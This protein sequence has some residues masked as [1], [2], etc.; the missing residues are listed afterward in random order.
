MKS[1]HSKFIRTLG[2]IALLFLFNSCSRVYIQEQLSETAFDAKLLSESSFH[3]VG[4]SNVH[5]NDYQQTYN[6][7][8]SSDEAFADALSTR[9]SN[10]LHERSPSTQVTQLHE[11]NMV[12]FQLNSLSDS[13]ISKARGFFKTIPEQYVI[14]LTNVQIGEMT[15]LSTTTSN[16]N[17]SFSPNGMGSQTTTTSTS[18]CI[19]NMTV[20]IWDPK[21]QRKIVEFQAEGR[22]REFL[23]FYSWALNSAIADAI[24]H[25]IAFLQTG[26]TE[27]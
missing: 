12:P 3:I 16:V 2:F 24:D 13:S 7:N 18:Y 14:N 21:R 6:S 11:V 19:V 25:S 8:F 22:A 10:A 1:Y 9:F 20:Q 5:L 23:F 26:K 15:T 4:T 17:P 27:F